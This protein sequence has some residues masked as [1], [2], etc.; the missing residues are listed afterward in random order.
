MPRKTETYDLTEERDRIEAELSDLADKTAAVSSQ[1]PMHAD[2]QDQ[3]AQLETHLHGV[4]WA[5]EEWGDE[6]LTFGGLTGGE[7]GRVEDRLSSA[8][9]SRRESGPM[10]GAA[11]VHMVAAGTVD[12]PYID[13]DY[14]HDQ[15]V[16]AASGLPVE[17]LKW[18]EARIGDLTTVGNG[19]VASF[20]AL[21]REKRQNNSAEN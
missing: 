7:Y 12:A 20:A 4:C 18:A 3:G 21:V 16:S 15:K 1:N 14:G 9:H 13:D 10:T 6:T 8:A 19:D 5:Q 11:R 17:F 2:L